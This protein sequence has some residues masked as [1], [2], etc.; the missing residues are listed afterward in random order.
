MSARLSSLSLIMAV[1]LLTGSALANGRMPG[2]NDLVFS[3]GDPA[4]LVARAT[5]G[6]V[7]SADRGATWSWICEQAIDVSG[8]VADPPLTMTRDGSLVLLPPTGSALVSGDRGCN[9]ARAAAP[10]AATRGADLTIDPSDDRRVLVVTSTLR[11]IDDA[12][13]GRYE[14]LVVETRDDAKSWQLLATLPSDFEA[15]TIEVAHSDARRI[16]VS[17]SDA[18]DA[19]LGVILRSDDAGATWTRTTLALPAGTGSLLISGIHPH[20]A[21]RLWV[22]VAARGDTLG[23]LPARLYL[24]TDKGATFVMLAMTTKGMFGFALSPDGSSL[25]YGGPS[26]GLF[27]GPSDGTAFVKRNTLGVRCLRWPEQSTL[28]VCASEPADAFSLGVS[29]DDGVSFRPLYKLSDTC[30]ASCAT[31]T[32]FADSC[33]AAWTQTR[34]FIQASGLMCSVPWSAPVAA[35]AGATDA[36]VVPPSATSDSG[37]STRALDAS[38][39]HLDASGTPATPDQPSGCDCQISSLSG[40]RPGAARASTIPTRLHA[41]ALWMLLAALSL[42]VRQYW[43]TRL[44]SRRAS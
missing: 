13:F 2:A 15:E 14:N 35:D 9:W 28:Y 6:I 17:G 40:S 24:S 42:G 4:R 39:P 23:F 38:A 32:S 26:D 44:A 36:S 30:P 22:R 16:Y 29:S 11:T 20:D 25:A 1:W 12:G 33:Q 31:G 21:D 5:F 7:Q 43:R 10:L 41:R 18:L 3:G 37:G 19:R 27:V 8:V 34:P